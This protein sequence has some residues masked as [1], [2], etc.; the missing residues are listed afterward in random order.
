[1]KFPPSAGGGGE[2]VAYSKAVGD[3]YIGEEEGY[4]HNTLCETEEDEKDGERLMRVW[5][6]DLL[7]IFIASV[8]KDKF[9][10]MGNG[11][12]VKEKRDVG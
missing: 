3:W 8:R 2:C 9:L 1:M 6:V 11:T 4:S 5:V 10:F 12:G 7:F